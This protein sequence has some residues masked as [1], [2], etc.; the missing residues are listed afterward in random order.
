MKVTLAIASFL[1][2]SISLLGQDAGTQHCTLAGEWQLTDA[3]TKANGRVVFVANS[4]RLTATYKGTGPTPM[5][6]FH[7]WPL[8]KIY[9]D[10]EIITF[11]VDG[12]GEFWF[13]R[14]EV[15][16]EGSMKWVGRLR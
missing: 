13:F 9:C 7:P 6:Q 8:S 11:Q 2:G 3:G 10:Y 15:D 12:W 14:K 1:I 16:A 5:D 4:G